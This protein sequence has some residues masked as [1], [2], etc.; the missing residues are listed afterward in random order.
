MNL[1]R[2][3]QRLQEMMQREQ[4]PGVALAILRRSEL[5]YARGFGITS[6]EDGGLSVTPQTLF[7][8]ASNTKTLTG[9]AILRLVQAG[10]LEL[11]CPI[12]AYL[13]GLK[14]EGLPWLDV[15]TLRM[16]LSH[17]AG[18]HWDF[19]T[20][21]P[22]GLEAH[23]RQELPRYALL[24]PPG[25]VFSYSNVGINLAGY[26][27]QVVSGRSF[28]SLMRAVVF[29]PLEMVRTTFVP[30]EAMTYP[31][32]QFHEL[33]EDGVLRVRH[34]LEDNTAYYPSARVF[35]T[36]LD[37]ANVAVM[38]LSGGTFRGQPFL[39]PELL[40]Q[41]HRLHADFHGLP[42]CP[43]PAW[44]RGYGLTVGVET[45]KGT[46]RVG[47]FGDFIAWGSK[48]I[49]APKEG[50]GVIW[51]Y[52]RRP[53]E[54]LIALNEL[55]D[56]IFDVLLGLPVS[57]PPSPTEQPDRSCWQRAVGRYVGLYRG[58]VEVRES[59]DALTIDW[60]GET[61]HLTPLSADTYRGY[62]PEEGYP[63]AVGLVLRTDEP[64]EYLYIN[65]SPCRR[66]EDGVL[67]DQASLDQYVGRYSDEGRTLAIRREANHLLLDWPGGTKIRCFPIDATRF[68]TKL[69]L[70]EFKTPGE[71]VAQG[72]TLAQWERYTRMDDGTSNEGK[73]SGT[74]L[75]LADS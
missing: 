19:G 12:S 56:E 17:T 32:A 47:H 67:S 44:G 7:R 64:V 4:I 26:I 68:G 70:L 37:L 10:M 33:G 66:V 5:T 55:T 27:A 8:I 35:S 2:F 25:H 41:M 63:I 36:V 13:S 48:V 28:V 23:V 62:H 43:T 58:L 14:E 54:F 59:E 18:L 45:Y 74:V 51:L 20:S 69:G 11:D 6:V 57:L 1:Y 34:A 16:L 40:A 61:I 50:V 65:G 49:L 75:D 38:Q 71:G 52:N 22:G 15:V 29:E 53:L 24:A 30:S 3:E 31:L 21:D 60:N 39:V 42:N 73:Q 9:L 72:F 46:H